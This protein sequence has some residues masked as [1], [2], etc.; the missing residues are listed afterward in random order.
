MYLPSGRF[1]PPET[2]TREYG[3][4]ATRTENETT[5]RLPGATDRD[6][7]PAVLESATTELSLPYARTTIPIYRPIS[8]KTHE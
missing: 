1:I 7:Q 3:G 5:S 4:G 6:T 8:R 2:Q